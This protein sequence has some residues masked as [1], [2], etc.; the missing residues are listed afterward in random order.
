MDIWPVT[1]RFFAVRIYRSLL[2]REDLETKIA[3]H[4]RISSRNILKWVNELLAEL[5]SRRL[6]SRFVDIP[7]P[8]RSPDLTAA[9]YF[10]LGLSY[11]ESSVYR[12][13]PHTIIQHK[14]NI[15]NEISAI[16]PVLLRRIM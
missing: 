9:D 1:E 16:D 15:Y 8:R 12:N 7:R 10:F 13:K 5:V 14:Q 6:I 3:R 2:S 4:G 11:L